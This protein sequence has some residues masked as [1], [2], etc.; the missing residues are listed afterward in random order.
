MRRKNVHQPKRRRVPSQKGKKYC[1]EAGNEEDKGFGNESRIEG[2]RRLS[3]WCNLSL[4]D[5]G[6]G[7]FS[8]GLKWYCRKAA[9]QGRTLWCAIKAEELLTPARLAK[10]EDG[11]GPME[12]AC[13]QAV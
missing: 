11:N 1:V 2:I 12:T 13:P 10:P 8:R 6:I 4:A 7:L 5:K 9:C 3:S